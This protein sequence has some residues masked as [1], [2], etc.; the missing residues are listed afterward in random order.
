MYGVSVIYSLLQHIHVG[1][2]E[3]KYNA[4]HILQ[5][6]AVHLQSVSQ[7]A[8]QIYSRLFLHCISHAQ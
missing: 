8:F 4:S 3:N 5:R 2:H 1:Y 7:V 6:E